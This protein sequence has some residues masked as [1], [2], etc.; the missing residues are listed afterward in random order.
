MNRLSSITVVIIMWILF[1]NFTL[2]NIV[3]YSGFDLEQVAFVSSVILS[4]PFSPVFDILLPSFRDSYDVLIDVFVY[5]FIFFPVY[6][7][8]FN[9]RNLVTLVFAAFIW[10]LLAMLDIGAIST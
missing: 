3:H 5:L 4:G 2:S 1:V 10:F 6:K 8:Y 9:K 7:L